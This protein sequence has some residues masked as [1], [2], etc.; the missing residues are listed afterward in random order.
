VR[1]LAAEPFS[2]PTAGPGGTHGWVGLGADRRQ[3]A[4]SDGRALRLIGE[5]V[6]WPQRGG[7]FDYDIWF[8]E[9]QRLAARISPG[10]G[11]A[12]GGCRSNR[13]TTL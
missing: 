10:F 3:L 11:C 9:L 2:V 6:C 1:E 8:G 7:T 5:N 4:T 13:A 12:P